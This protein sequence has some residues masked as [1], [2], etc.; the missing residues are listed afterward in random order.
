MTLPALGNGLLKA[1]QTIQQA[2]EM[3]PAPACVPPQDL[4]YIAGLLKGYEQGYKDGLHAFE[5]LVPSGFKGPYR[6]A[7]KMLLERG[8]PS[9]R[10]RVLVKE[11]TFASKESKVDSQEELK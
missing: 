5:P 9:P 1:L 4:A 6:N 7:I 10:L 3:H 8:D 2:S 11:S